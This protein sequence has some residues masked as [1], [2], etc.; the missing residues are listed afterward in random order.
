MK[1]EMKSLLATTAM[2]DVNQQIQTE[3]QEALLLLLPLPTMNEEAIIKHLLRRASSGY[4]Q[5]IGMEH[6]H[7]LSITSVFGNYLHSRCTGR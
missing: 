1:E 4:T 5:T 7:N 6:P 3:E 2:N